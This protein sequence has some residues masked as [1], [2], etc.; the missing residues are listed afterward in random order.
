MGKNLLYYSVGIQDSYAEMVKISIES[1]D[2]SNEDPIDILVITDQ[3][4]HNKNFFNYK[5]ANIFYHIVSTIKNSDEVCFNKL[6]VFDWSGISEYENILYLDGDTIVNCKLDRIFKK[7]DLSDKIYVAVED[8]SIENHRRI[9]FGLENYTQEDLDFFR[10]NEIYTFNCGIFLFKNSYL[11]RKHF[12]NISSIINSWEGN[13]F[14]DQ[15]FLNYYFNSYGLTISDKIRKEIDFVYVVEENINYITDFIQKI[16]HFL[17]NTYNG[18][19]KIDKIKNFS[20]KI[21]ND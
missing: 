11:M 18:E 6:K 5:R 10:E 17:G 16:F 13:F 7:C 20:K 12:K 2:F 15:S 4:Y 19:S 8:Y 14:A 3:E 21:K 1:V 9:H